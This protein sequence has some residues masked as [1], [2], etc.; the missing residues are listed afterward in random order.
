MQPVGKKGE[1]K[2]HAEQRQARDQHAGDSAGAECD[3]KSAGERA[4]RRL[5][6]AHIGADRDVH[7]DEA[8][9]SGQDRADR[10]TDRDQPAEE[11]ADDEEDHDADNGD[12]GVLPLQIGLRALA[13]RGGDLLHLLV[14]GVGRQ[15]RA[16]RP[17]GVDDRQSTAQ[18]DEP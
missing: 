11:I 3:F 15:H 18:N 17:D 5:R 10:K 13:H 9:R 14:A 4:D 16:R 2:R 7:A 1:V 8:R 12:G 6:G